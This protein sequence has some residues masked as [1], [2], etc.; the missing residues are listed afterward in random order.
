MLCHGRRG[1]NSE[2]NINE[3]R[4][5]ELAVQCIACPIPNVNLLSN[6]ADAPPQM[7]FLYYLFLSFDICFQL[8]RKKTSSWSKDPSP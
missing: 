3:T 1:N 4:P 6:W 7:R 5:G 8:K 2:Q